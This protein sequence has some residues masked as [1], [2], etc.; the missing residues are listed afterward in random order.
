MTTKFPR[1][2]E[3]TP[4]LAPRSSSQIP[5]KSKITFTFRQSLSKIQTTLYG[6]GFA[7]SL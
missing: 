3:W 6:I 2:V 1:N 4:I 5:K 7:I